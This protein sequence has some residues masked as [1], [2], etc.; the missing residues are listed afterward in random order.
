MCEYV[1]VYAGL[2][3]KVDFHSWR[4]LQ[5]A[6]DIGLFRSPGKISGLCLLRGI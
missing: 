6:A 4:L 5:G 3:D 1:C 2:S